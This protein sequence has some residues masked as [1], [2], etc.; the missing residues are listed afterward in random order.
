MSG[1]DRSKAASSGVEVRRNESGRYNIQAVDRA[2]KAL[3]LLSEGEPLKLDALSAQLGISTSS[4]YRLL[5]TLQSHRYVEADENKGGYRLGLA[6]LELARSFARTSDIR[7][8][9][10]PELNRLRDETKETVH[11]GVL[12]D[13]EVVY[14]EKLHGLHPIGL[15]SSRVGGRSPAHCTGLGKILLAYQ[16]PNVVVDHCNDH[17]L[18]EFTDRTIT[19]VDELTDHLEHV[20]KRG[21]AL[22]LG[23]HEAEVRCVAAPVFDDNGQVVAAISISGPASRLGDLDD[24]PEL[25]KRTEAAAEYV[26]R[27]LGHRGEVKPS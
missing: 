22:D 12:D 6:C 19:D 20:R 7:R 23:E 18:R 14:L 27:K 24:Q 2:I 4:T 3:E 16:P 17:G 11:L 9:A 5:S 10:L 15:M 21:Y 1:E 13:M 25:I 26:S 8:M